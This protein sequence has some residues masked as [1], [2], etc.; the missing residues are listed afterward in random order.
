HSIPGRKSSLQ[1]ARSDPSGH[2]VTGRDGASNGNRPGATLGAV[3]PGRHLTRNCRSVPGKN[4]DHKPPGHRVTRLPRYG[5]V[6][7]PFLPAGFED[8]LSATANSVLDVATNRTSL[9]T[10]GVVLIGVSRFIS[11]T[12]CFFAESLNI[13]SAPSKLAM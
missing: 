9:A 5:P 4:C 1:T 3:R 2:V 13:R 12:S 10:T 7:P 6:V 11:P 8:A